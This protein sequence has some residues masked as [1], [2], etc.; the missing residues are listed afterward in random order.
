MNRDTIIVFAS[1]MLF[2]HGV[3]ST[4]NERILKV[5]AIM[6][7]VV[8]YH[9][10]MCN[11]WMSEFLEALSTRNRSMFGGLFVFVGLL[12]LLETMIMIMVYDMLPAALMAFIERF[13]GGLV[14]ISLFLIF[15]SLWTLS[16][17]QIEECIFIDQGVYA[18]IRHPYYLGLILLFAG[19]C[20]LMGTVF[21]ALIAFYVL[22][23]RV[24]E[25]I[26]GEEEF[27]TAKHKSYRRYM[28]RVASGLPKFLLDPTA[29]TPHSEMEGSCV[30]DD[31]S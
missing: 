8:T 19:C 31:A 12:L 10:V 18:Y 26:V 7:L 28:E 4:S 24:R 29:R 17:S 14:V 23:E 1:G 5:V 21:S 9:K 22:K 11:K 20:L 2:Y 15:S 3:I 13:G 27:L 16:I 6:S 30:M 25:F